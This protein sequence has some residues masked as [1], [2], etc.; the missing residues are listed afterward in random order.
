MLHNAALVDEKTALEHAPNV[1]EFRLNMQGMFTGID[2]IDLRTDPDRLAADG[3]P[4]GAGK[5][6]EDQ[7]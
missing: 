6:R 4:A 2:S 5:V 1:D 7:Q 3:R